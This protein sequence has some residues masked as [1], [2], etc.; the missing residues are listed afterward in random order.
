[1]GIIPLALLAIFIAISL[2]GAVVWIARLRQERER[3]L[4]TPDDPV[5]PI[6][7]VDN[8]DA[9]VVAEGR[10]HLVFANDKARLW[11]G[12]DGGEPNLELMADLVQPTDTF[13][14]LFGKEGQ[15]S[16]RVGTRRIEASSHRIPRPDNPQM[17]VVMR[18]IASAAYEKGALDPVQAMN[19]V[20]EITQTI[21]ASLKLDETL[22]SI[23]NS[24]GSVVK[25]DAGEI[26]LWDESLRVLRPLGQAGDLN[27]FD[28]LQTTD[29]VYHLDDSFSG[30]V[31]RYRQALLIADISLRPDVRP[32]I[33]D[34]PFQ[35]YIGMPLSV[36]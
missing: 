28:R 36:G 7:L 4:E 30:W 14:E 26:T 5:V 9:V 20:S 18:E 24:V 34:Y 25:F 11:F 8:D 31:A 1:M 21:S 15:A 23:L 16:F 29:G 12:I 17:V 33:Q 13:L 2:F 19:V 22:A 35:S 6:N 3:Y 27:Y 10:G 32:K